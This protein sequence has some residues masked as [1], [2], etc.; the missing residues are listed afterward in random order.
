VGSGGVDL[1]SYREKINIAFLHRSGKTLLWM[2]L[3]GRRCAG[4]GSKLLKIR[5][6]F[7]CDT[8]LQKLVIY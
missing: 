7:F 3:S 5:I 4:F 1:S 2:E 8:V 6:L